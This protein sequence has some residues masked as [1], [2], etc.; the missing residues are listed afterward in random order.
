[1]LIGL[2]TLS[3]AS[4]SELKSQRV[5]F[6]DLKLQKNSELIEKIDLVVNCG[7]IEG[8]SGIPEGWTISVVRLGAG[9]ERLQAEADHGATRLWS[10][11]PLNGGIRVLPEDAQCF[12][13]SAKL[14]VSGIATREIV[15]ARQDLK[16]RP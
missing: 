4:A 10:L 1:V 14:I 3:L 2:L 9:T 11:G 6:P 7:H 8:I 5:V 16:L 13:L 12:D 15:L